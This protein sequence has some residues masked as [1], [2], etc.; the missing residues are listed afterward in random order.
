MRKCG[1]HIMAEKVSNSRNKTHQTGS[2]N[3][4]NICTMGI[5]DQLK[6]V[7]IPGPSA[8]ALSAL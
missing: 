2:I 1:R 7:K 4:S 3:F 5:G 6:K 8:L